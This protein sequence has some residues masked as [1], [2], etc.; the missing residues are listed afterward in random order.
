MKYKNG[1]L[2]PNEI[3]IKEKSTRNQPLKRIKMKNTKPTTTL[4]IIKLNFNF[5]EKYHEKYSTSLF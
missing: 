4:A 3:D 1:I 5:L 2:L